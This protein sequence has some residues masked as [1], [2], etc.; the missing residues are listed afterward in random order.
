MYHLIYQ[1]T[2]TILFSEILHTRYKF[3]IHFFS[4]IVYER[5]MHSAMLENKNYTQMQI[6]HSPYL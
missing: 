4:I 6:L 5:S 3:I 2:N 1:L